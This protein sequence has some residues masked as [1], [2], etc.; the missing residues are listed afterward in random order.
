[1]PPEEDRATATSNM[2]NNLVKIGIVLPIWRYAHRQTDRLT[3]TQTNMLITIRKSLSS[4]AYDT[5]LLPKQHIF[6]SPPPVEVQSTAIS[7]FASVEYVCATAYL[8]KNSSEFHGIFYACCKR[9]WLGPPLTTLQYVMCFRFRADV[10]FSVD[11]M[12]RHRRREYGVC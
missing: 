3:N 4:R 1:M 11:T 5:R 2:H 6:V 8:K 10:T 12:P 9:P 7:V